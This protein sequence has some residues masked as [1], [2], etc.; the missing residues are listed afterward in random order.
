MK[1]RVLIRTKLKHVTNLFIFRNTRTKQHLLMLQLPAQLFFIILD[2][3]RD[4]V[5]NRETDINSEMAMKTKIRVTTNPVSHTSNT[6]KNRESSPA[7]QQIKL[8]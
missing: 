5:K 3:G 2:C 7:F 8:I 6:K 1:V 4:M